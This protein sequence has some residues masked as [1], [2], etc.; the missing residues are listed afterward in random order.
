MDRI[1]ELPQTITEEPFERRCDSG[2]VAVSCAAPSSH[3]GPSLSPVEPAAYHDC[4]GVLGKAVAAVLLLLSLPLLL[5]GIL[6]VRLS[7]PG[8]IFYRQKRLGRGG[9]PFTILKL[10]TMV[11]DAERHTGPVWAAA[12]DSRTTTVGRL[13]RILNWDE[14]PQLINVIKG[15]MNIVGPRPERPEIAARLVQEIPEYP[16]R[17]LVCPGIT[18][19]AQINLPADTDLFSVRRKLLLDFEYI[20]SA[21][22]WMDLCIVLATAPRLVGVRS[23]RV[24]GALGVHRRVRLSAV[25]SSSVKPKT[26]RK[27]RQRRRRRVLPR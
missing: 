8:P 1:A 9:K 4:P 25:R 6:M 13:L 26:L 17:T 22:A 21:S 15:E 24:A 14:I 20:R 16:Q 18:G 7:T 27:V 10:R 23:K 11:A 12:D 2:V 5:L 3:V 19:L